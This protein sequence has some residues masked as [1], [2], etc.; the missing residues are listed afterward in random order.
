MPVDEISSASYRSPLG[1]GWISYRGQELVE[2]HLPASEPPGNEECHPPPAIRRLVNSLESYFEGGEWPGRPGLAAVAGTT[3]F[4][5]SVY[6]T[7]AAI[8]AGRVMT[9][10]EVAAAA[11]SPGAARAVGRAMAINPFP[12]VIPCHRV[13][14]SNGGLG[15]FAGGLKMKA[16]MLAMEGARD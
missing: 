5:E 15:G 9:Y 16:R 7:V 14:A 8:P 13:V 1:R 11:G 10:G 12:V 6:A 3:P 2:I 4:L